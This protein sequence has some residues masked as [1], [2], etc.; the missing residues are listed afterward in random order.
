MDLLGLCIRREHHLNVAHQL[1]L[2]G[3]KA[4]DWARG[5]HAAPL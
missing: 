1:T 5:D 3:L 4:Q 2:V